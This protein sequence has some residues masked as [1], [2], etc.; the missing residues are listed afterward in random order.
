[1]VRGYT[2][3]SHIQT[4]TLTPILS[5]S[6]SISGANASHALESPSHG[7]EKKKVEKEK[8]N[9]ESCLTH[10]LFH[11]HGAALPWK[12]N[13][14]ALNQVMKRVPF[15]LAPLRS[16]MLRCSEIIGLFCTRT[17][18]TNPF[19]WVYMRFIFIQLRISSHGFFLLLFF[20]LSHFQTF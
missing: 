6:I 15:L 9:R 8:T 16:F 7:I 12:S 18:D 2:R 17:K 4:C 11:I 10:L 13:Q 19:T 1:M 3:N 14:R 5:H 20:F